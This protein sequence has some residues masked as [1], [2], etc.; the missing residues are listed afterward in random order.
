MNIPATSRDEARVARLVERA[1][2]D[3]IGYTKVS[4]ISEDA[5]DNSAVTHQDV[6]DAIA[7]LCENSVDVGTHEEFWGATEDGDEWRVHLATDSD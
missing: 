2:S 1:I 5:L 3:S 7:S 4:H 6:R